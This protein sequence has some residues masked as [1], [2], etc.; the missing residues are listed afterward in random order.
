ME[1]SNYLCKSWQGFIQQTISVIG[2]GY[3]WYQPIEPTKQMNEQQWLA[4]DQHLM[5][6]FNVN[7]SK[8][9]RYR[10]KKKGIAN[11]LYLRY[12]NHAIVLKTVGEALYTA[13]EDR[14]V[15]HNINE[16]PYFFKVSNNVN[17]KI[18]TGND[19]EK[20]TLYFERECYRAF[21]T[22]FTEYVEKRHFKELEKRFYYLNNIPAYSGINEQK[23]NLRN[24]IM[25]IA[26]K[27]GV[28][29]DKNKL[30]LRTRRMTFPVFVGEKDD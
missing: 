8:D 19:K 20:I 16:K 22:D 12:E 11:Y 13:D 25:K 6:K 18:F 17:L 2:K 3:R 1:H 9:K 27:N 15:F 10:Q 14:E 23:K 24:Y 30:I 7:I 21:R 4:L 29:I 5:R 26:K 28:A